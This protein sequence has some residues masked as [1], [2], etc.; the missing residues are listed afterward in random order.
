MILR[1]VS[2]GFT[3]TMGAAIESMG[4]DA[5]I[6]S[7]DAVWAASELTIP[8]AAA[9]SVGIFKVSDFEAKVTNFPRVET[10]LTLC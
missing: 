5:G 6:V 1:T 10:G 9:I 7:E 3:I 2:S 8:K 4:A